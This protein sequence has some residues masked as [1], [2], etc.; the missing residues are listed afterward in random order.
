MVTYNIVCKTVTIKRKKTYGYKILSQKYE[1]TINRM[2]QM[3]ANRK[4]QMMNSLNQ[5]APLQLN[6]GVVSLLT[7]TFL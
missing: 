3:H 2:R 5:V 4:Q 1:T 7:S 6:L